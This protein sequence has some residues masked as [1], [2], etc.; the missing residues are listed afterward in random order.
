MNTTKWGPSGWILLH[1]VAASYP[2]VTDNET[3]KHYLDF[4]RILSYMLPCKYCRD[5]Y[6]SYLKKLN[7]AKR[8]NVWLQD[9]VWLQMFV[10]ILHGEVNRKLE[11]QGNKVV[12]MDPT[13]EEVVRYYEQNFNF[14]YIFPFIFA[15]TWNYGELPYPDKDIFLIYFFELLRYVLPEHLQKIYN[16]CHNEKSVENLEEIL[17][18]SHHRKC[19]CLEKWIYNL[20]GN[21]LYLSGKRIDS[22][23]HIRNKYN[24]WRATC[25]QGTC[26]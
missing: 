17:S 1:S 18:Q 9:N 25:S 10:Y 14:K 26:R 24:S 5:S 2:N 6:Q 7:F 19:L 4:F 11:A 21:I 22:F 12:M 16:Y 23:K 15:I 3:R 20:Y 8:N 13:F